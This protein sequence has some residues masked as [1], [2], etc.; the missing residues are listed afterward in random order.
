M[1]AIMFTACH[2]SQMT[3][4]FGLLP[5]DKPLLAGPSEELMLLDITLFKHHQ[6]SSGETGV[7]SMSTL[8]LLQRL[9]QLPHDK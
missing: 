7:N 8:P 1:V 4:M 2:K 9:T 3:Q 6:E 5:V